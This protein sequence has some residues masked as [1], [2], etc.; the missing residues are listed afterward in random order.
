MKSWLELFERIDWSLLIV[1]LALCSIS[2]IGL[3]GIDSSTQGTRTISL[4]TKHLS[5]TVIGLL[6]VFIMVLLVS[7]Q[8]LQSLSLPLYIIGAI[9][10]ISVLF[11]GAQINGTTGWFRLGH[12]S[13]QPVELAKLSL[14]LYTA[15]FLSKRSHVRLSWKEFGLSFIPTGIYMGL[16]LLQPDFGSAM[17]MLAMWGILVLFTGLPR[18][19]WF[20]IPLVAVIGISLTWTFALKP[21]QKARIESFLNPS[22]DVKG[23]GYNA[24]QARIAIGSGGWIG[25]GA[26]EG[27]QARLRFLPEAS[28]DFMIAVVGEEMGFI[29]IS[30]VLALFGFF[31]YRL[32]RIAQEIQQ[33]F[34]AL[35]VMGIAAIFFIHV[36]VNTGM[37]LGL[38]PIT[39]IPLPFISSASSFLLTFCFFAIGIVEAT[40]ARRPVNHLTP[41]DLTA[42]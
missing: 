22:L 34:A 1:S 8:L 28:T 15:T 24:Q 27:S 12:L 20:I 40:S 35:T 41:E 19:A 36:T 23:S 26:G 16:I 21:F 5:V 18:H 31:F 11:L 10:L 25:K 2:M 14:I 33:D 30:T 32:T 4:F 3:Y 13:F 39:G 42:A 7:H 29:G 17:T 37:N 38:L 6:V 9:L